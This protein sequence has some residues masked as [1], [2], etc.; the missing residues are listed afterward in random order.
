MPEQAMA[1]VLVGEDNSSGTPQAPPS[2]LTRREIEVLA[3][4]SRGWTRAEV[5]AVLYV[6]SRTV[7]FHCENVYQK[8]G[9]HNIPGAFSAAIEQGLLPQAACNPDW[10][11]R[12]VRDVRNRWDEEELTALLQARRRRRR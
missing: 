8:L 6:S 1:G 9:V 12:V 10:D 5:S 3:L 11:P 4:T 7:D 2:H